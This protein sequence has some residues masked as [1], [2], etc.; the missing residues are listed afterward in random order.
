MHLGSAR[1]D[2]A[3]RWLLLLIAGLDDMLPVLA[4]V[5]KHLFW[6]DVAHAGV[7][8]QPCATYVMPEGCACGSDP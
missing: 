8:W 4:R 2:A 5:A 7:R 1:T 3:L 6:P